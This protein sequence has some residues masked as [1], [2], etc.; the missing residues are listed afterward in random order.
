[1]S[2]NMGRIKKDKRSVLMTTAFFPGKFQPPHLGHLL[3]INKIYDEYDKIIIGVTEGPPRV[4]SL[5]ET[6]N[7]LREVT[8]Y[9]KK[10]E[11]YPIKYT[12]DDESAIPY[13]PK[14][15]DVI[16]TG[17]PYVIRLAKKY[18]WKYKL[19]PRSKGIGY[20]GTELRKL[21]KL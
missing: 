5:E 3:T 16:L 12:M 7:I 19:I 9:M 1:M 6:C 8:K 21:Y 20:S 2:K 11:I 13:L 17:N 15:W 14:K 10:I 18:N 4:M